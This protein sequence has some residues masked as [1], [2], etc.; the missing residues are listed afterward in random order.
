M[1]DLLS[2]LSLAGRSL[3]TYRNA[4]GVANHNIQNALTPGYA[5]QRAELHT[6]QP[7]DFTGSGYIGR[8][9]EMGGV[10]QIRDRF[11]EAQMPRAIGSHAR[12]SSEATALR[13][14]SVL[15]P[16][17]DSGLSLSLG[18]FYAS[19]RELSGNAGDPILR[20][21]VVDAAR[22]LATSFNRTSTS[23]RDA[24]SGMNDQIAAQL[25]Q[26]NAAASAI[27]E[28]NGQ[29]RSA[30]SMGA[31]PNDLVDARQGAMD[32]LS[33]LTGAV[34]VSDANGNVSMVLESGASL[35][36]G[37]KAAQLSTLQDV[38]NSGHLKVQ[39]IKA[40]G[41][42]PFDLPA[43]AVGG[44][45]GGVIDAR[46]GAMRAAEEGLDSFAWEFGQSLNAIHQG[47]VALDG[48]SGRDIFTLGAG[49]PGAAAA[50]RVDLDL[51]ADPSLLGAAA[52]PLD[53]PGNGDV[54]FALIE[55]E[56][57]DLP[58]GSDPIRTLGKIIG[59]FGSRTAQ[60]EALSRSDESIL[61]NLED[62]RESASGVSVD[63]ELLEM[64]K[65][66]RAFEAVSKV[67]QTTDQMLDTLMKL[68]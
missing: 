2:V 60:A 30:R 28:L 25:D 23:I 1:S 54:L 33:R 16:D 8:G 66:Q 48:S 10:F 40:D 17:S 3:T 47:G 55:S 6:V 22:N 7:A 68:R 21:G 27:A 56:K 32:T 34:P 52:D 19:L 42:G 53:L 57:T 58:S 29:I 24:R 46:D 5:R 61:G 31:E 37:D 41:R 51:E 11:V 38:S 39:L 43:D 45:V 18:K 26:A 20:Q 4:V 50:I 49:A 9:V 64:M 65:Y 63:E 67:I 35:V 62:M 36:S 15:N 14:V 12:S 13:S 44:M 59:A